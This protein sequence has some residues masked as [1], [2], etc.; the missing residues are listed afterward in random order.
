[1]APAG[2]GRTLANGLGHFV[3]AAETDAD[4]ATPIADD[5]ERAEAEAAATLDDLRHAVDVDDLFGQLLRCGFVLVDHLEPQSCFACGVG[6]CADAAVVLV[7]AAV[8]HD[9]FHALF[10]RALGN[11]LAHQRGAF[12]LALAL[13]LGGDAGFDIGGGDEGRASGIVDDLGVDVLCAAEDV[14]ARSLGRAAHALAD[15]SVAPVP[16]EISGCLRHY[17]PTFPALPALRRTRS[18][19]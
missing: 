1:H 15:A 14:E 17:L 4:A 7:P 2:E 5:N 9:E 18:P 19:R 11:G 6:E 16:G 13:G 12:E 3:G 8:E 10:L